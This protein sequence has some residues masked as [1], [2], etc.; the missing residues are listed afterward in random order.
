MSSLIERVRSPG[1][2]TTA[3]FDYLDAA[4]VRGI[5]AKAIEAARDRAAALAEEAN[6]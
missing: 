2:T 6:S 4:E 5:F 3:A 1:G